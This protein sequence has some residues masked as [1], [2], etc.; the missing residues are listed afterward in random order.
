MANARFSKP[1]A[2]QDF[3]PQRYNGMEAVTG[4]PGS[5][6]AHRPWRRDLPF[7]G[8]AYT[9]DGTPPHTTKR[10]RRADTRPH[11]DG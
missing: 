3:K 8:S 5:A 7:Y 1:D 9:S 11:V 6:W 4:H 2:S 10:G